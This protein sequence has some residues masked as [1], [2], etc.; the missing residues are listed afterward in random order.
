MEK[1]AKIVIDKPKDDFF[2]QN[3]KVREQ[4]NGSIGLTK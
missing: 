2:K 4:I 3:L 1:I